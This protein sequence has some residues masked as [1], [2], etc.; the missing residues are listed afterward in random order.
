MYN[1]FIAVWNLKAYVN[2]VVNWKWTV[3]IESRPVLIQGCYI[4]MEDW[5]YQHTTAMLILAAAVVVLEVS[6]LIASCSDCT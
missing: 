6:L 3:F 4:E 1:V 5:I 2:Y